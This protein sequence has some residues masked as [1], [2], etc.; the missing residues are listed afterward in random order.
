[1]GGDPGKYF[2][3]G[4]LL[5]VLYAVASLPLL[6]GIGRRTF[7]AGTGVV[8]AW[9]ALL[10]PLALFHTQQI[11]TDSA[12]LFFGLLALLLTLR[13]LDRPGRGAHALAGLALG[14]AIGT[15][16]FLVTFVPALVCADLVL[17]ARLRDRPDERRRLLGAALVGLAC[18]G[19]GFVLTTPFF[20]LDFPSVWTN[21][22]H[23]MREEHLG[24]DGLSFAGNL[25]WYL[26]S[27][28]PRT[29]TL[30]WTILAL[31]G[32]GIA[33]WRRN[34][35]ALLVA[36]V[37][38]AFVIAISTASLHWQRWLIQIV[39]LLALFIAAAL[40]AIARAV[41]RVVS[42][43]P[44]AESVLLVV[45]TLLVSAQPAVAYFRYSAAQAIPSTR[46]VAREWLE[47]NLRPGSRIAADFY[48]APLHDTAL[49]ADYHFSLAA[50][51]DLEQYRDAGYDY[52]M[53][54]DAIYSRYLRE[55][56]RY[57]REVAFYRTL[58]K[59][60][61]LVKRFTP[62]EVGRGP[63]ISVYALR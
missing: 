57:A 8:A 20:L 54:S 23:E 59:S 31:A 25:R 29:L 12:G 52:L 50:D 46:V 6:Y 17:A 43:R 53:I 37:T 63:T 2:L 9:L 24:A 3:L 18:V 51:G 56:Q 58:L 5:S 30:P 32:L 34:V 62:A 35:A 11:R 26:T 10:S 36:L 22:S 21:L 19:L 33:A 7:G 40:V 38:A 45:L 4:R 61:Q 60:G 28:L 47:D 15:R 48:T 14:A 41:A 49:V 42:S 27:A 39:P 16:Y 1:V 44:L 13:V 55:R